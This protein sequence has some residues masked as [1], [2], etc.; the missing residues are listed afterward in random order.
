MPFVVGAHAKRGEEPIPPPVL[1]PA[2]EPIEHRLP[3]A[4]LCRQIPPGD[5]RSSP[6]EDSLDEPAIVET[7]QAH[8]RLTLKGLGYLLPLRI[9]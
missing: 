6:P 3:R 2:I 9:G 8:P 4:E 1:G 5:P 7:G